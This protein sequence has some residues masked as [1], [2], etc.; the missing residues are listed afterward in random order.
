MNLTTKI[1]IIISILFICSTSVLYYM[2]DKSSSEASIYKNNYEA[3]MDTLTSVQL[4]NGEL[5]SYK[6]SYILELDELEN[7]I[8]IQKEYIKDIEEKLET[9]LLYISS[10]ESSINIKDSTIYTHVIV[11]DTIQDTYSSKFEFG[12]EWYYIAGNINIYNNYT[13]STLDS[14][15]MDLPLTVGLDDSWRI[16]V[17]TGNPYVNINNISGAL[18]DKNKYVEEESRFQLGLQVGV[19]TIYDLGSGSGVGIGPGVGL[20]VNIRLF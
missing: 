8:G 12:D 20:G 14:L 1:L 3:A 4:E 9:S 6:S 19:Y 18:L 15:T 17:S 11:Y 10:I 2:Y 5:M 13:T 16:F 7:T